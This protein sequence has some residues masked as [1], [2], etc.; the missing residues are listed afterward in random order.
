MKHIF[1]LPLAFSMLLSALFLQPA[2][3]QTDGTGAAR[4]IETAKELY[5]AGE[6]TSARREFEAAAPLLDYTRKAQQSEIQCYIALCAIREGAPDMD[7]MVL[8]LEKEFPYASMLS[9]VK[10]AQSSYYFEKRDYEHSLAIENDLRDAVLYS[11]DEP[12]YQFEKAYSNMML[13][14]RS[15]AE[16]GYK[17]VLRLPYGRYTNPANYYLGYML[18]EDTDFSAAARYLAKSAKDARYSD[19]AKYYLLECKLML[20]DY[21]YVVENGPEYYKTVP[22]EYKSGLSRIISNA[23]YESGDVG[24]AKEYL[25]A[26]RDSG[27]GFTRKDS[28]YSGMVS[29]TMG[30]YMPAIESFGKA[31]G[32]DSLGQNA[33]YHLANT[34]LKVRNK[35]AACVAFKNASQLH[36]DP[37][38]TEDAYYNYAKLSFDVNSDVTAFES[39]L[40]EYPN[41][42][43][44][45]EISD[46]MASSF[47]L[48]KDYQSAI[49]ALK[50]IKNPTDLTRSNL[51]KAAFFRGLEYVDLRAYRDAGEYFDTAL[52]NQYSQTITNLS[53]I[54]LAECYYRNGKYAEAIAID[55]RIVND[56]T[57]R[58]EDYY[59]S[60]IYNLAYSY[61]KKGDYQQASNWFRR[62][63]DLPSVDRTWDSDARIRLADALFMKK[64]F[65]RAAE[66]YKSAA[67][68]GGEEADYALYQSAIAYGLLG[69]NDSK[70]S[71]LTSIMNSN[72]HTHIYPMAVYEL[73]RTYV[74]KGQDEK[75]KQCFDRLMNGSSDSTYYAKSLLELA[76]M[77]SNK[78][79]YQQS[80]SY[81]KTILERYPLST[82]TDD[83]L[84]GLESVYQT[85]G[86]PDEFLSYLDRLG[87]SSRKSADEKQLMLFNAAE[88]RYLAGNY[89]GAI[90]SL[91][92][93][94]EKYPDG[95]KSSQ[96]HYYLAECYK[97]TNR[98][99]AA[100]DE[101]MKVMN[102]DD[103]DYIE[104]ATLN[105]AVVAYRTDRF[106]EAAKA[107]ETLSY[108]A[109]NDANR[110]A[111][112]V[113]R[114]LACYKARQYDAAV[115]SAEKVLS[116]NSVSND[117]MIQAQYVIAKSD[118]ALGKREEANKMLQT[119]SGKPNTPEGAESCY[120]LAQDAYDEGDFA[121][122][123]KIVYAFSDSGSPQRYWLARSFIVLGDS[124]ADREN[125]DQ[126]KATF[127]SIKSTYTPSSGKDDI[128]QQVDMRLEK[129]NLMVKEEDEKNK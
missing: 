109:T 85:M 125:W 58:E 101:Y 84:S 120:L 119:L 76:M 69:D 129:I 83:A 35:H 63:L 27:A 43:R 55:N 28:Y 78:G 39:Y 32:Q 99:D 19:A 89:S 45:D 16:F 18:Y 62:Y 15:D 74:Q 54:Y 52:D 25:D 17:E 93:F 37:V 121:K 1:T 33:Y 113:G 22:A 42:P 67:A 24:K 9:K 47:I 95:P 114:M 87:M 31:V 112:V 102:L 106:E 81:Y 56:R 115:S 108:I 86:Q 71:T 103:K 70:V 77:S 127:D 48:R 12:Q 21:Q 72:S 97:N 105:F 2:F 110:N 59:P 82:V 40:K 118:I 3:A 91:D 23:Y 38:I 11:D 128:I 51:Q 41:S 14:N 4:R 26:Y 117:E 92:S 68:G 73:G 50:R 111:A 34:Y 96:A 36:F 66:A 90:S 5:N 6:W 60:V 20:K 98:L 53:Y 79:D 8:K 94:L 100:A 57:L 75:A 65:Q 44:A 30:Q 80:V 46:Y 13:K 123:E 7:G 126:A 124:F 116:R 107:Y 10:L 61:F 88:Q 49:D 104:P 122:T 64:D 29:F